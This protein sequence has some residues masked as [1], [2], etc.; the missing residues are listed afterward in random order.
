MAE[1]Q[2]Q[3]AQS[4]FS[5]KVEKLQTKICQLL[6]EGSIKLEQLQLEKKYIKLDKTIEVEDQ[7]NQLT[8]IDELI[9]QTTSYINE[10]NQ[11][12]TSLQNDLVNVL[13]SS[14]DSLIAEK[15]NGL[16]AKHADLQAKMINKV[17][18]ISVKVKELEVQLKNLVKENGAKIA[19]ET[20]ELYANLK[21][22]QSL[23]KRIEI[24]SK[25][26][27]IFKNKIRER[28]EKSIELLNQIHAL[29]LE[30]Q[31][32]K[33]VF[34]LAKS[35]DLKQI[36]D[37][38]KEKYEALKKSFFDITKTPVGKD[39]LKAFSKYSKEVCKGFFVK[40]DVNNISDQYLQQLDSL[41]EEGTNKILKCQNEIGNTKKS[42]DLGEEDKNIEI[43][44]L[45]KQIDVAKRYAHTTKYLVKILTNEGVGYIK[46][47]GKRNDLQVRH[48]ARITNLKAI[49]AAKC[50]MEDEK[51]NRLIRQK[52]VIDLSAEVQ[53]DPNKDK[54][55][56]NIKKS[57]SVENKSSIHEIKDT[58]ARIL[59]GTKR[60]KHESFLHDQT[61]ITNYR[62]GKSSIAQKIV[63]KGHSIAYNFS[64]K[65]FLLNN[66]IYLI[67]ILFFIFATCVNPRLVNSNTIINILSNSSIRVFF[68]LGVAGLILLAGTDLSIGRMIGMGTVLT[69]M[70]LQQPGYTFTLFGIVVDVGNINLWVRVGLALVITIIAT[71]LFSTLAG[72]FTAKFKMHPFISTLGTQLIIYGLF[73]YGTNGAS[74]TSIDGNAQKLIRLGTTTNVGLIVYA[75]IAIFI[76]WFIWNKTKFGRNLYAVGGN[77]EAAA[78]SGISVFKITLL[79]FV[80]A[81]I[82]YGFGSFFDGIKTTTSSATYGNGYEL[83]AIAACV[84][85]GVSFSGGIGKIGGVVFGTVLFEMLSTAFTYLKLDTN[86]A[87]IVKGVIILMAV[88]LDSI[89][90]LKKK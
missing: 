80:M 86:L 14:Y 1:S 52:R 44:N 33:E 64:F 87:F 84:V 71:T 78:V 54:I 63:Q 16:A 73:A 19:E 20:K 43:L 28:Q 7:R 8:K 66:G 12:L 26:A 15:E 21:A 40:G 82:L 88:T 74:T 36:N 41:R 35:T 57:T 3:K 55:I 49:D 6:S 42:R 23:E 4:E 56:R 75:I 65:N 50:R 39:L 47:A 10:H 9:A 13:N 89:K 18:E 46:V 85:G 79:A 27:E 22:E 81:G 76:V 2:I 60:N 29:N 38:R 68:S 70:M 58:K 11:E 53:N 90:Y 24:Q 31:T 30:S 25:I 5:S 34:Y 62:N 32:V 77:S 51:V 37:L 72:F 59:R 83:D 17:K 69:T 61:M 48:E 67:I 45:I